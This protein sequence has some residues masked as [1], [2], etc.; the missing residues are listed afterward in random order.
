MT[1]LADSSAVTR[2][3]DRIATGY[4]PPGG[5]LLD[6]TSAFAAAGRR[7]CHRES[8]IHDDSRGHPTGA[9]TPEHERPPEAPDEQAACG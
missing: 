4:C 2:R 9:G 7:S 3:L 5:A 6:S 8:A 1:R